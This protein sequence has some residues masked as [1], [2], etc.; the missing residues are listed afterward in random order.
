MQN[1]KVSPRNK[2]NDK[3][4]SSTQAIYDT[5]DHNYKLCFD[6]ICPNKKIIFSINII[7]FILF[8][9]LILPVVI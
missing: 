9:L 2:F 7:H 8:Y 3:Y 4:L 5:M 6:Y 1:V